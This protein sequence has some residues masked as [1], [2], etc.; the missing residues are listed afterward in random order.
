MLT[1]F[2]LHCPGFIKYFCAFK[3]STFSLHRLAFVLSKKICLPLNFSYLPSLVRL[4]TLIPSGI[5]L[6][7]FDYLPLFGRYDQATGKLLLA[8][9]SMKVKRQLLKVLREAFKLQLPTA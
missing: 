9:D 6:Y 4:F 1:Q 2:Y 3:G 7:S 5:S 8:S